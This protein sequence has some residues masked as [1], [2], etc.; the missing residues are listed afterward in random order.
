MDIALPHSTASSPLWSQLASLLPGR[1]ILPGDERYDAARMAWNLVV[2][3]HP[4]AVV[5]PENAQEV[6]GVVPLARENEVPVAVQ[7]TGHGVR[8]P[9]DGAL[10]INTARLQ[11]LHVDPQRQTA[12]VGA[13]VKWGPVL[14]LAQEHGLAPLLGSS[15][16][17][18]AVGY[19]LG[20]GYGWLGRKYGLSSDSVLSLEVVTADGAIRQASPTEHSDL[21]WAL[22]GG[23]G[24]FGVVTAVG[25]QLY[26]VTEV[27]AGNLFYPPEMAREVFRRYREWTSA[28]PD[29]LTSPIVLI[30][31]PPFPEIPEIMRGKSFV[32]VRGCYAGSI[33]EGERLLD[34]WRS[35]RAP[36]IDQFAAIPFAAA[37]SISQGPVDP[38]PFIDT[39]AWLRDLSDGAAE[40]LISHTLPV[41]GPP[42]LVFCEV[43]HAGGAM[44][45]VGPEHSA[46]SNREDPYLLYAVGLPLSPESGAQIQQRLAGLHDSLAS[47][48]SGRTYINFLGVEESR[49]R[50]QSGF[51]EA[52]FLRLQQIKARYDPDNLFNYAFNIPPLQ[53]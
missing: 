20:G 42:V 25:I 32:I 5:Y 37:A 53:A 43:R 9:A 48:L 7:S 11:G 39:G 13:G 30:N 52:A 12:R 26:P 33:E 44:S 35:W 50:T 16:D 10:L 6:A 27:Y 3:Q 4:L 31:V 28:A 22:R 15:P 38:S 41:D 14:A 40:A 18:G 29:E 21:F 34:F 17:V 23:G 19:S 45:R 51:S 2:D 24:A 49:P 8:R 47:D 46:F 1:V 36:A